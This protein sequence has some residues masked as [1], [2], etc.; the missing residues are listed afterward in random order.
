M[1]AFFLPLKTSWSNIGLIIIV[2]TSVFSFFLNG[3]DIK[4]FKKKQAWVSLP[5]ILF[6]PVLIG[7][8]YSPWPD[9]ALREITKS[10]FLLLI[11][12]MVFRKDKT[13]IDFR[14]YAALGLITGVTL[15]SAFLLSI[16]FYNFFTGD[17]IFRA[18][19]YYWFTGLNFIEPL[20]VDMH[21]IYLGSYCVMALAFLAFEKIKTPKLVKALL[22]ILI[23]LAIV[24]INSRIIFF[25]T[26][27]LGVL[28]AMEKLSWKAFALSVTSLLLLLAVSL[29]F[30][31]KT[32]IYNKLVKGTVWELTKNV[33]TEIIGN[34]ADSRM[35]R[36]LVAW[37]LIEEKPI[38]GYGTGAEDRLLME[39]Y[40]KY[41]MQVSLEQG[42][43][44]HNQFLGYMIQFGVFGSIFIV[45]YFIPNLFLAIKWKDLSYLVYLL[46][47]GSIFLIE[48]YLDRNMGIS[49][50]ALF[51]TLFLLKATKKE[52]AIKD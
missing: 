52:Q 49:L 20:G 32:Y 30:M 6:V 18:L 26:V 14:R 10:I 46:M 15:C 22:T 33:N 2:A 39:K 24:F 36:W 3:F 16:T 19:F 50:V 13:E 27:V 42:Y 48:N 17:Y 35:S 1:A 28:Y 5:W 47:L 21:P 7:V 12:L 23:L 45:V 31:Q 37:E 41:N 4:C 51:G 9:E 25:A 11:P 29:P 38:F 40:R 44:S 43:N 8:L 34:V